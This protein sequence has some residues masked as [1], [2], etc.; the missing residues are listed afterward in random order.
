MK[1]VRYEDVTEAQ[2][3]SFADCFWG[4]PDAHP[5]VEGWEPR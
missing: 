5:P 3:A 4:A 2:W 1:A